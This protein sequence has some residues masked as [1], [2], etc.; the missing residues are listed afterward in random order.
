MTWYPDISI[1]TKDGKISATEEDGTG[2]KF[3]DSG[4]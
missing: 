4:T 1:T 2:L 3:I